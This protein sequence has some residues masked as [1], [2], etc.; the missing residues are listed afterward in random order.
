MTSRRLIVN[1]DDF[2]LTP[3]VT[4]GV[5]EAMQCGVVTSTSVMVNMPGWDDAATRL[6]HYA[7]RG[8]YGLHLNLVAGRPLTRARSLVDAR[9]GSFHALPR[10]VFLAMA[11]VLRADDIAVE[12][13]A[14]LER[15]RETGIR[16]THADS[17]RHVH[18]LPVVAAAI[19]P[20]LAAL[21]LRLPMESL[22]RNMTA[23]RASAT[24]LLLSVAR[25][26]A[27]RSAAP[28]GSADH[29]VGISLQGSPRFAQQLAQLIDT[30]REGTTELMVHPGYADHASLGVDSYFKPRE[31]ELA[32]LVS[33]A[34][35]N[36]L[37]LR[38]VQLTDFGASV[39]ATPT[40]YGVQ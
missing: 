8:S 22:T 10:F 26:A 14:Q 3:G 31:R 29:F 38:G 12:C 36:R 13:E 5:V 39:A 9:S 4:R 1:A 34:F 32:S 19:A 7:P 21:P 37:R 24:K 6:R 15:L 17:H 40:P 11:G 23:L 30:L 25:G 35:R 33:P 28:R 16:V 18:V 27:A 2:G 20:V